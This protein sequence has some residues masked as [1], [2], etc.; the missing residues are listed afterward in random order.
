MT[1]GTGNHR[2]HHTTT[3]ALVETTT[4]Q[5]NTTTS[6]TTTTT[7]PANNN[8]NHKNHSVEEDGGTSSSTDVPANA[9]VNGSAVQAQALQDSNHLQESS[10]TTKSLFDVANF[11]DFDLDA[12]LLEDT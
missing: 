5:N 12:A 4:R 8:N 2:N 6:T 1:A 3:T 11:Q 10:T 9:P 7:L